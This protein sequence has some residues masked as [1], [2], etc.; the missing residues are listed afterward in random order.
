MFNVLFEKLGNFWVS[1]NDK[2]VFPGQINQNNNNFEISFVDVDFNNYDDDYI[3]L[4]GIIENKK[5][6]LIII[7]APIKSTYAKVINNTY[8]IEYLFEGIHYNN[9]KNIKF[10]NINIKIDNILSTINLHSLSTFTPKPEILLIKKPAEEYEANLNEFI[11]GVFLKSESTIGYSSNGQYAKFN[12]E[13]IVKL[14]YDEPK[15]I[16]EIYNHLVKIKDLFTFLTGKSEIIGIYESSDNTKINMFLPIMAKTY[17]TKYQHDSLIQLNENNLEKIFSKWFENYNSFNGVYD[18]YFSTI[19]S[20]LSNETLFLTYCQILE[21]YHRKKYRGEY[22]SKEKFEDFKNKFT[23]CA[24]KMEGLGEI[25]SK[26]N[27]SQ[28]L[29]KILNSI[30]YS[31][32]FTLKDRLKEIFSEFEEFNLFITIIDKF[33]DEETL[34]KGIKA[35]CDLIKDGRNYYTHYGDE[36]EHLLKGIEF[37][38]L[39]DSLNLIIKM[40]FLKEL[41]LTDSEINNITKNHRFKFVEYYEK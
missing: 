24:T 18:L 29:N 41:G 4:N 5:L 36:P 8:Y 16:N 21:S 22:V 14:T 15:I 11:L 3:L 33:T 39:T 27:K 30:Q 37:L 34:D 31:Y 12:E 28:F 7:N 13:I 1:D 10:E 2:Q 17:N 23:P 20:N 25:V 38:E 26:E 35:Y 19:G 32:E 9:K 40:I 6:S